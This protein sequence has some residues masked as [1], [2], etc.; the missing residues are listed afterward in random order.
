VGDQRLGWFRFPLRWQRTLKTAPRVLVSLCVRWAMDEQRAVAIARALDGETW[1]SGGGIW[2]VVIRKA[3]GS[4]VV[5]SG[6]AICEYSDDEAFERGDSRRTILLSGDSAR[7][8][9]QRNG[10]ARA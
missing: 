8:K 1:Q 10:S 2:L 4:L 7:L 5:I 3:E 6:D 9:S